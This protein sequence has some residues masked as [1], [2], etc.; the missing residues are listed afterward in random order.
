LFQRE[1]LILPEVFKQRSCNSS[2][3]L[4]S[5][6]VGLRTVENQKL[7]TRTLNVAV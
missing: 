4:G 5:L 3:D 7:N 6:I 2:A 1:G